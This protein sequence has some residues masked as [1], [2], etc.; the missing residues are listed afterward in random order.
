MRLLPTSGWQGRHRLAQRLL[1]NDV[2]GRVVRTAIRVAQYNDTV[3]RNFSLISQTNGELWLL[4]LLP[5]EPVVLDVGFFS[6]DYSAAVLDARPKARIY[7]FD[8]G[9]K[10]EGKFRQRF[11]G[12]DQLSFVNGAVAA[13]AGRATFYDYDNMCSSLSTRAEPG[14]AKPYDVEV[15]TLDAWAAGRP[16]DHIDLLKSDAEGHDL[17]VLQGAEGLLSSQAID[18]FIFEFASGWIGSRTYLI[19]VVDFLAPLPYTLYRLFNGFLAPFEYRYQYDSAATLPA[20]YV[21][22]SDQRRD[23]GGIPTKRVAY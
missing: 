7:A 19:D 12:N 3:V 4:D 16:V 2:G 10:A 15:V 18:L 20:M 6:G 22:V 14:T 1:W 5:D 13:E 9:R 8:P 11:G 23:R 21:G 17:H